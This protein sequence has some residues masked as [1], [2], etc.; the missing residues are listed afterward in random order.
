VNIVLLGP[1]GAGKGTQAE[2]LSAGYGWPQVATGDILRAALAQGTELGLEAK[3][4]MDSGELV[5]DEVVEGIVSERLSQHDAQEG[6]ILDGFPRN[7][8]QAE[9]LDRYLSGEGRSIDLVL[10]IAV[11]PEVLARRIAGRRVCTG[12]GAVYHVDFN[13]PPQ[14]GRCGQCGGELYQREDDKEETV[15][16]RLAVYAKQTEPLIEYYR[17]GGRLVSM[18]GSKSAEEVFGAIRSAVENV[19]VGEAG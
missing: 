9:A 13:P 4:Y 17:P 7:T 1:P 12:C 15:R 18:D 3:K 19:L 8:H 14:G 16:N 6:F 5:P 2:E 11:E 10:N